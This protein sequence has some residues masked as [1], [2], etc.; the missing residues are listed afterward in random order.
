MDGARALLFALVL[1]PLAASAWVPGTAAAQPHAGSRTAPPLRA[2]IAAQGKIKHVVLIVQENRTFDNLFGGWKS[3]ALQAPQPFNGADSVIPAEVRRYMKP[4]RIDDGSGDNSHN[5]YACL[6]QSLP[7]SARFSTKRWIAIATHGIA[8]TICQNPKTYSFLRYVP[9]QQRAVYWEIAKKYG[10]GDRF[11]AATSSASFPPHQFIVAGEVSFSVPPVR[12]ISDQP[13]GMPH[14]CFDN[15]NSP[16]TVP[17]VGPHVFSDNLQV[18]GKKGGCYNRWTYGDLFTNGNV[19]WRHYTTFLPSPP[20]SPSPSARLQS[21]AAPTL[22]PIH[23]FNGFTNIQNWYKQTA[24]LPTEH[25]RKTTD[26]L[27]DAKDPLPEFMWVKPP[28]IK[29]SDHPNA[30]GHRGQNW[31]GSVINAIGHS[32]NW[33]STVIFVIWDDWGGFYDHAIPPPAPDPKARI[34]GRGVRI[35]VLVISPYLAHPGGVVHTEGH[36]GS[37]LRFVDDLYGLQPLTAFDSFAPDLAGWF[38][39]AQKPRPFVPIHGAEGGGKWQDSWCDGS[40]MMM[41][42]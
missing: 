6:N 29:Q 15:P 37:I 27:T 30:H 12:H 10:L 20:P 40:S 13:S 8:P 22:P 25:F 42:D 24:P 17:V 18:T 2:G 41:K 5:A 19:S 21:S 26:I 1:G 14:G 16:Y 28:C 11:F 9:P 3:R 39:F 34:L 38:D 31:V 36:P 33:D 32:P 35:P 7:E 23:A 4:T